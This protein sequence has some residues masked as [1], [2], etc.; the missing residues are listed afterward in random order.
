MNRR[1]FIASLKAEPAVTEAG[2]AVELLR[3][4][5]MQRRIPREVQLKTSY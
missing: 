5:Q 4:R 1:I 3:D 2:I